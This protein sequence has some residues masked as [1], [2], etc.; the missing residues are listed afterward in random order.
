MPRRCKDARRIG[1]V[2][3][4]EI[5]EVEI[6]DESAFNDFITSSDGLTRG[7]WIKMVRSFM[8]ED[9][10][11]VMTHADLHPRNIIIQLLPAS[12]NDPSQDLTEKQISVVAVI[13]W[14]KSGWYPE[15]WEFIKALDGLMV[16]REPLA[17]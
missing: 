9:H 12:E 8:R 17:D 4:V 13:D 15:Y 7:P 14:D 2:A 3:A 6:A 1:R 16:R 5:A 10:A 11:C